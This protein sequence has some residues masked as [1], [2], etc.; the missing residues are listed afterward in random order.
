MSTVTAASQ[1]P[2]LCFSTWFSGS[3]VARGSWRDARTA[4]EQKPPI[5]MEGLARP[6]SSCELAPNERGSF[7][8]YPE[9][10]RGSSEF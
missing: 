10:S 6:L 2:S 7:L 3:C 9:H 4:L 1:A 8:G 5:D